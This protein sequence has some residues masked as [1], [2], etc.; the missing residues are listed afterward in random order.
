M[1]RTRFD[2]IMAQ[3]NMKKFLRT[4]ILFAAAACA[5]FFTFSCASAGYI[6]EATQTE[7]AHAGCAPEYTETAAPSE[8]S[9]AEDTVPL[10]DGIPHSDA[11][12]QLTVLFGGDIMAHTENLSMKDYSRIWRDVRETIS[13]ADIALANIEAPVDT[14]RPASTYPEFNMPKEYVEAAVDAGFRVFSLCN[15]H[16][17]DQGKSGILGTARTAAEIQGGTDSRGRKI[18]FSGLR[19]ADGK[20]SYNII[21]EKGWKILFLPMTE[22]LNRNSCADMIN[23][24]PPEEKFRAEFLELCGKLYAETGPDLFIVSVHAA[25]PEYTRRVAQE[26]DD[27][28]TRILAA[29]ADVVW[30]NHA[31]IIKDRKITVMEDGAH[32]LIMYANGNTISGQRRKPLLNAENVDTERDNT[33]DGILF[34]VAFTRDSGK[35][36]IKK[37]EPVLITT[38]INTASEFVLKKLDGGFINYLNEVPRRD[39]AKYMEKRLRLNMTATRNTIEWK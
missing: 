14:S 9:E 2:D 31:H 13:D 5:A 28:Y 10:P 36:Q 8:T 3:M 21:E 23:F 24:V 19:G 35:I 30:A 17:N 27:W 15:N 20:F 4:G 22:I 11:A 12:S 32:K 33:G 39:W 29:G 34:R 37:A 26:Q 6:Q 25:E 16:T 1:P 18:Y 38:Y 7:S